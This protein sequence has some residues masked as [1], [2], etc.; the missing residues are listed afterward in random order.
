MLFDSKNLL[1]M[2]GVVVLLMSVMMSVAH[3]EDDD[4]E[5]NVCLPPRTPSGKPNAEPAT[6][7]SR[8]ACFPPNHGA[9]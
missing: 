5:T 4:D 2:F 3:A 9:R 6:W 1:R 8:R 7:L